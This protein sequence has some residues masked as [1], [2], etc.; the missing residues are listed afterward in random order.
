MKIR[1][2]R[3]PRL[4]FLL[5]VTLMIGTLTTVTGINLLA[6][7]NSPE[8]PRETNQI[9]LPMIAA[10]REDSSQSATPM[11]IAADR[12]VPL[13]T[14]TPTVTPVPTYPNWVPGIYN[15]QLDAREGWATYH[16]DGTFSERFATFGGAATEPTHGE[17]FVSQ[18]Q[19]FVNFVDSA[20]LSQQRHYLIER[21]DNGFRLAGGDARLAAYFYERR[22]PLPAVDTHGAGSNVV[23]Q[24]MRGKWRGTWGLTTYEFYFHENGRYETYAL[25]GNGEPIEEGRWSAWADTLIMQPTGATI[26]DSTYTIDSATQNFVTIS[27]GRYGE[28][29]FGMLR[30]SYTPPRSMDDYEGQYIADGVTITIQKGS[31]GAFQ[32]GIID[33]YTAEVIADGNVLHFGGMLGEDGRLILTN[34][35]GSTD[36]EPIRLHLNGLHYGRFELP[37]WLTKVSERALPAPETVHG[38]WVRSSEFSADS[39]LWLLPDNRY[40]ALERAGGNTYQ[41]E[42][43]YTLANEQITFAARCGAPKSF[44]VRMVGDQLVL[45][46]DHLTLTYHYVPGKLSDLVAAVANADEAQSV[47]AAEFAERLFLT[48]VNMAY[49]LHSHRDL[50]LDPTPDNSFPNATVFGEPVRF[51]LVQEASYYKDLDGALIAV[52]PRDFLFNYPIVDTIDFLQGPWQDKIQYDFYPNGR[53]FMYAETY[54]DAQSLAPVA[55]QVQAGWGR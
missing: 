54:A 1:L 43:S 45:R 37:E 53:F 10:Q 11:V 16:A 17:W 2:V 33:T 25:P 35:D 32:P 22:D 8:T 7:E 50:P 51:T 31:G 12:W 29:D 4:R 27:S 55:P 19:L 24:W 23:S 38:L 36:Y 18:G 39:D 6:Q 13:A 26:A 30:D 20:G 42:G 34:S 21:V 52:N 47:Q 48:K 44:A 28:S 5:I 41:V 15:I 9:Y 14:A 3:F 46:D 49:S 40:V